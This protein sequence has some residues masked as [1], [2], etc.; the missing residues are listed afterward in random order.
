[1]RY[2][3]ILD[4]YS[5]NGNKWKINKCIDDLIL[6]TVEYFLLMSEDSQ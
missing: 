5:K 4:I 6:Q 3:V 1:M 2:K